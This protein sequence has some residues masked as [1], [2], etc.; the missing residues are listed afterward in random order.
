MLP[1]GGLTVVY[2]LQPV[3]QHYVTNFILGLLFLFFALSLFGMYEIALPSSL[4]NFHVKEQQRQGQGGVIGTFF[5][6]LTFT[7]IS[8]ACVAPFYGSFLIISASSASL[9]DFTKLF[10][11][12]LAYS[13]AFAA[14]R[15]SSL[16]SFPTLL[17]AMPRSG[18][19]MNT[20]KVVMGFIELAAA[21]EVPAACARTRLL[22]SQRRF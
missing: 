12:A 10:F 11:G 6:A 17:K 14:R 5:M 21:L 18:S 20:I 2:L 4:A 19:W 3:S 8:F 1:I 7:I 15:F 22:P 13:M 9:A 16:A